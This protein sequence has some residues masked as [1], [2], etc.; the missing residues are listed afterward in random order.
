M[1]ENA[2]VAEK[3]AFTTSLSEWSNTMT[4][5]ISKRMLLPIKECKS[6]N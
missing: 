2:A 5:L 6:R 4:G 1:A 3:K